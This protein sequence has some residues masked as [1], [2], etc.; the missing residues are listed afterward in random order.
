MC[1]KGIALVDRVVDFAQGHLFGFAFQKRAA[2]RASQRGDQP[3]FLKFDQESSNH[4]GVRINCLRQT[5]RGAAIGLFQCEHSHHMHRKSKSA[6]W[7]AINVTKPI[8]LSKGYQNDDLGTDDVAVGATL[9]CGKTDGEGAGEEEADGDG[10]G[11]GNGFDRIS[12]HVQRSPL[13][14][15]ISFRR[16][17][18]RSCN[19]CKSGGPGG[20]SAE[21]GKTR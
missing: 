21:P 7:H 17:E 16:V 3:R 6:A 20:S 8:T 2:V 1:R 4:D 9:P 19:L 18:Q 11:E 14:P 10:D 15:P 12:S 13:Y 5:R